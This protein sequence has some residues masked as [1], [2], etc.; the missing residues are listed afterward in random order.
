MTRWIGVFALALVMLGWG[1]CHNI[2][3]TDRQLNHQTKDAGRIIKE[4]AI[5]PEIKQAGA[6]V[7]ANSTVLA[8]SLGGDPE[9]KDP[10][11]PPKS[12]E[13][14]QVKIEE[15]KSSGIWGWLK[16]AGIAILPL[17]WTW[18]TRILT[19]YWPWLGGPLAVAGNATMKAVAKS[20]EQSTT[21]ASGVDAIPVSVLDELLK[22][23]QLK[24]GVIEWAKPY[25]KNLESKLGLDPNKV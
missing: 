19:A 24:A 21:S 22:N 2:T 3:E 18:G 7:E 11:S 4:K 20:R 25:V 1:P 16:M 15:Q 12:E 5:D 8:V 13:I 10:Y 6:D 17:A 14:R 9:K 23:E